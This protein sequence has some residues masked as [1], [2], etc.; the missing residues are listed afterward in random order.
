ML[1][2]FLVSK[3]PFRVDLIMKTTMMMA[4]ISMPVI[5]RILAV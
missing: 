3:A 2:T 1:V 4:A 5:L